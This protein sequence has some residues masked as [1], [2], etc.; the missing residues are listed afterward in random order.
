M[1]QLLPVLVSMVYRVAVVPQLFY[2]RQQL[3]ARQLLIHL[4]LQMS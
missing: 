1:Q 4:H 3:C 2:L